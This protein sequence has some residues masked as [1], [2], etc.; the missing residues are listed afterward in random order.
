LRITKAGD[1]FLRSLLVECAQ[2]IVSE[3]AP[4]SALKQ[5]GLRLA[6]RGKKNAYKRAV[7][8]V[9][10][11]LSILLHKLW[12]TGEVYEPF[13]GRAEKKTVEVAA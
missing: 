4:D 10:R 1:C 6:A 9:A 8:A 5:F 2:R 7:V 3:K 12:V 13:P 11:K